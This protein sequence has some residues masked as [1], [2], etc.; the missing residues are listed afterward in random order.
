MRRRR[1]NRNFDK[2]I[3][4]MILQQRFNDVI[5]AK[6]EACSKLVAKKVAQTYVHLYEAFMILRLF[7]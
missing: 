6:S 2:K 4:A 7:M 1:Q 3:T 5:H